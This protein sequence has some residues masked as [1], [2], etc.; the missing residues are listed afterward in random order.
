MFGFD[1]ASAFD[2][3]TLTADAVY[4]GEGAV[5]SLEYVRISYGEAALTVD[6]APD[7]AESGKIIISADI[8][9]KDFRFIEIGHIEE[10]N[11]LLP[12]VEQGK[13]RGAVD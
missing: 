2:Y 6:F 4:T 1:W 3:F 13:R 11:K 8:P 12:Y 5:F 7:Y 9:V 10:N